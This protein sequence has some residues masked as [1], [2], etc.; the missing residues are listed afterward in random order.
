MRLGRVL[1]VQGTSSSVGKSLLVAGLCR[2]FARRGMSVAPFKA[3]NMSNNAAVCADG[4]EIGRAQALQAHA[5]GIAPTVEMNPILL[6]PE[7]DCRSQ[8]VVMGKVWQTLPARSYLE[9]KQLLWAQVTAALD[10][11]RQ[12]YELVLIEGAGSPVELNLKSGDIVNMAVA[13]HANA[14]VLLVGDIDRGGVFAQLLGTLGLLPPE[15]RRLVR[16]LV[17]NKFR[18]DATLFDDGVR[19]LEQRSG[20]PVLGVIPYLP[21]LDLPEED[22]ATLDTTPTHTLAATPIRELMPAPMSTATAAP[23]PVEVA[24][25]R[26]PRIANFDD[27]DPLRQEPGVRLRFVDALSHFGQPDAIIVPGSKST[28]A[29]LRWLIESGLGERIVRLADAG[30]AVVGICG[31]YQM[32]GWRI[33]DPER[34]ESDQLEAVGLGLL[35]VDTTFGP[36]KATHQVRARIVRVPAWLALSN[37][38]A[39]PPLVGYEIHAGQTTTASAWLEIVQRGEAECRVADGAMSADD[40]VWGCYLHGLFGNDTFRQ[41]WLRSLRLAASRADATPSAQAVNSRPILSAAERLERSLDRL[42]DA[43]AQALT[44]PQI[45]RIIEEGV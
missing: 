38:L 23:T 32:L 17:V 15:E 36:I 16:G 34:V 39:D 42:A 6:K 11:L 35:P 5:A 10:R 3:Q 24:V 28:I 43:I 9:R 19:I 27:F 26:L 30:R 31:G 20:V 37:P 44:L 13:R 29:D 14:P 22:A 18:G 21:Q 8:V 40:R 12:Q 7:A 1:M 41:A 4:S 25:V 33:R 2:W 45:E